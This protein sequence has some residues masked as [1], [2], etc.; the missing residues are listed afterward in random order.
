MAQA[1]VQQKITQLSKDFNLQ[2]KDVINAF[3]EMGIEKKTGAAIDVDE[4][5]LFFDYMTKKKQ[6]KNLEAYTKG[7]TKISVAKAAKPAKEAPK[8]EAP[9]AEAPKAEAPK[10]EAPKAET[11]LNI[12]KIKCCNCFK[13]MI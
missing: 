9:K 6:I 5:E 12:F 8:A 3:K 13:K 4:L 11:K 2:Q 7:E 10:A 1:V